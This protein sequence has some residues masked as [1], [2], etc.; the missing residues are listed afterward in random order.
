MKV[1]KEANEKQAT[2]AGPVPRNKEAQGEERGVANSSIFIRPS[3]RLI[4][5]ESTNELQAERRGPQT[6]GMEK[7]QIAMAQEAYPGPL[8]AP[9]IPN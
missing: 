2:S 6:P 5:E 7:P 3:T 4:V 9:I 8:A 1:W